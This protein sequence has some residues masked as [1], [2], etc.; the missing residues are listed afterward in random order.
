MR[1]VTILVISLSVVVMKVFTHSSEKY[2]KNRR[3]LLDW[4][5]LI[6]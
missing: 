6:V 5:N 1:E 4:Y 3:M 2:L